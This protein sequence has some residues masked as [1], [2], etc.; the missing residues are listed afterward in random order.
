[1]D[2][3]GRQEGDRRGDG[4]AQE[5]GAGAKT[6]TSERSIQVTPQEIGQ[7]GDPHPHRQGV[8]ARHFHSMP[9][10]RRTGCSAAASIRFT[11]CW[12]PAPTPSPARQDWNRIRYADD[13]L[14][15][16]VQGA[17][18]WGRARPR[19]LRGQGL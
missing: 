17:T 8:C 14:M 4:K 6:I 3:K 12:R 9:A 7:G 1:M 15:L 11:R 19:V 10:A 13:T 16:C 2:I 5:L 18:H